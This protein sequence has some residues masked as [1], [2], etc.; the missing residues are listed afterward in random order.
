[1]IFHHG[2]VDGL[3]S[4]GTSVLKTLKIDGGAPCR[5]SRTPD[6]HE[7]V[8]QPGVQRFGEGVPRVTG[9]LHVQSHIDGLHRAAPL[10]VH[11]AARQFL[12]QTI[13]LDSQQ[14]RGKG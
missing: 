4:K 11:L 2:F 9:L 12:L 3:K 13:L 7:K 1:M 6:L 14:E 5:K 10:A 8:K